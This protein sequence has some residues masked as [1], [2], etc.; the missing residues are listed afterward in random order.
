MR[1]LIADDEAITRRVLETNLE[2]WG[3]QVVTC[4]DGESAWQQLTCEDPPQLAILDWM[5][6][7]L[8]GVE[9]CQ[10][11]RERKNEPYSYLILLTVRGD[12]HDLVHA[13]SVGADDYLAKPFDPGELEVRILAGRRILELQETLLATRKALEDKVIRDPLTGLFNRAA[14][15][16]VLGLELAREGR[17][18]VPVGLAMADLD[19]FK[20]IND[21]HGHL[22]G[23]QALRQAT[24]SMR[25]SIRPYDS[26]GRYGGEEFLLVLPGCGL[27][28]ARLV[29]ERLRAAV[30][31]C[32]RELPAGGPITV[33]LGVTS[34]AS[35]EDKSPEAL[36]ASADRA[37]YRAKAAGRNLVESEPSAA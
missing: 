33:S 25:A 28:E 2:R 24:H 10:R 9:L 29:A 13:M 26:L 11:L 31:G 16:E 32:E 17:S 18:K 21:S 20:Q 23:D 19:H 8:S 22:V 6:P 7:G 5:M 36:I 37:L 3:Y 1:I 14:I 15:L 12:K 34:T 27:A 4:H 30:Q 35:V